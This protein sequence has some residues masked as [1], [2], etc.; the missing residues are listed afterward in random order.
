MSDHPEVA[1]AA[2]V[3]VKDEDKGQAVL[4]YVVPKEGDKVGSE[5]GRSELEQS[6]KDIV[7]EK[8]GAIAR[9]KSVY[10]VEALPKTRSGK[11]LRRSIQ[12]L[13][14]SRDP[15]DLS[16]LEDP[17]ALDSVRASTSD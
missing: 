4:A 2:T 3:G 7:D 17:S 1:E 14:E 8:I 11:M 12:A 5:E 13:A 16:T 15:G 9:P 10:F 6:I